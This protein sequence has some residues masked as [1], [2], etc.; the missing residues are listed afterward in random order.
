MRLADADGRPAPWTVILGDNG[1]GKT[2]LLQCLVAWS[3]GVTLQIAGTGGQ[4]ARRAAAQPGGMV[5]DLSRSKPELEDLHPWPRRHCR[6]SEAEVDPYRHS[7]DCSPDKLRL[8]LGPENGRGRRRQAPPKPAL[9]RIWRHPPD[10]VCRLEPGSR[11]PFRQSLPGSRD[12]GRCGGMV[13]G[14]GLRTDPG[15]RY[16]R[17]AFRAREESADRPPAGHQGSPDRRIESLGAKE[18]A[19]NP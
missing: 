12:P 14:G 19:S 1:V 6:G 8:R 16:R 11:R 2:T 3:P 5:E 13:A 10:G 15:G 7:G 17:V 18:A 4:A 9:L